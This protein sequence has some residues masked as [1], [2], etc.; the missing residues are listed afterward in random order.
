[1][2][3]LAS[4]YHPETAVN[5]RSYIEYK[6]SDPLLPF[7]RCFWE[8]KEYNEP[9]MIIPDTCM[10]IVFGF[11]E[12]KH[13]NSR[14]CTIDDKTHF[15]GLSSVSQFGIRFYAWSAC[16]FTREDFKRTKN[17]TFEVNHFF[18]DIKSELLPAILHFDSFESRVRA[19]EMYLLKRLNLNRMNSDVMNSIFDI[20]KSKGTIKTSELAAANAISVRQLERIFNENIGVSPK[21]L[22]SLIRYQLLWQKLRL[23]SYNALDL[24]SEFGYTDQSHLLRDFK[25]FHSM[26][27]SEATAILMK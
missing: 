27:P 19:S 2:F 15:S 5:H 23:K 1:M 18:P 7:V 9:V 24:T 22:S 25:R 16:L 3:N 10:D 8:I 14:F 6:P 4:I 11:K 17:S 20:I 13:I 12:N 26:L 21:P